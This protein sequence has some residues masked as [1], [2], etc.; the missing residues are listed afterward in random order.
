M[1]KLFKKI[2]MLLMKRHKV[3][4]PVIIQVKQEDTQKEGDKYN[5]REAFVRRN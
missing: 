1:L 4:L 3:M 2:F 5:N